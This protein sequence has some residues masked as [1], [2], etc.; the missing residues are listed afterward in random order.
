[1]GKLAKQPGLYVTQGVLGLITLG[2][3]IAFT[4]GIQRSSIDGN[5]EPRFTEVR[6]VKLQVTKRPAQGVKIYYVPRHETST[7]IY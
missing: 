1:M 3:L 7:F 5:M 6:I 4:P 2:I